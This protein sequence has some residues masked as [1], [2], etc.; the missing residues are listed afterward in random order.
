G[1]AAAGADSAARGRGDRD[2]GGRAGGR[3]RSDV[4]IRDRQPDADAPQ[5]CLGVRDRDRFID[6]GH[7]TGE[8]EHHAVLAVFDEIAVAPIDAE[9]AASDVGGRQGTEVDA[10]AFVAGKVHDLYEARLIAAFDGLQ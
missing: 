10:E 3:R 6:R 8:A 7:V 4:R 2:A 9:D 1:R 5:S